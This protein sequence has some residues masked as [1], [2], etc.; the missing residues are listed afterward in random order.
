MIALLIQALAMYFSDKVVVSSDWSGTLLLKSGAGADDGVGNSLEIQKEIKG[1]GAVNDTDMFIKFS[2]GSQI[3]VEDYYSVDA[4]GYYIVN[5]ASF[6][7]VRIGGWD[8]WEDYRDGT[9][10]WVVTRVLLTQINYTHLL[11]NGYSRSWYYL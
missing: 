8:S 3:T 2:D 5:D 4:E 9:F 6:Q 11:S 1:S 7:S 10:D